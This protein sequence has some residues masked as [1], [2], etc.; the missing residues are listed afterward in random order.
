MTNTVT[1]TIHLHYGILE[2]QELNP[3][4]IGYI[5]DL[6]CSFC[7]QPV[8]ALRPLGVAFG[9]DQYKLVHRSFRLCYSCYLIARSAMAATP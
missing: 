5:N 3:E 4:S 2:L 8:G 7:F 1:V 9:S 6:P